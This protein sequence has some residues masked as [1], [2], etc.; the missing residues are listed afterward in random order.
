MHTLEEYIVSMEN[1]SAIDN[2]SVP[3]DVWA[4]LQQKDNDL[5]LA[6]ELGKALLE[7]NEELKKQHEAK[8]E[9]LS[10]K[11]ENYP[12]AIDSTRSSMILVRAIFRFADRSVSTRS[13]FKRMN[14]HHSAATFLSYASIDLLLRYEARNF[15]IDKTGSIDCRLPYSRRQEEHTITIGCGF[16][17]VHLIVRAPYT[18][19]RYE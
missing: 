9:E 15:Y 14:H 12:S 13:P 18:N 10:K 16:A 1:R 4:Q 17:Y 7:K 3:E 5:V 19:L 2:S 11:L 8:E 6:A